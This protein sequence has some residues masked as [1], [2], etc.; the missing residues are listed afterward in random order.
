MSVESHNQNQ[1]FALIHEGKSC[2]LH[3]LLWGKRYLCQNF[4]IMMIN[5]LNKQIMNLHLLHT[6]SGSAILLSLLCKIILHFYLD[7]IHGRSIG[8]SSIVILP[9]LYLGPYNSQVNGEYKILK[10]ICNSFLV[11]TY[12]SLLLNII[13]GVL[14]LN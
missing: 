12:I 4:P 9:L 3:H 5:A 14:I 2:S 11:F 10:Y 1:S 8:L 6:L 7:Y 13:I